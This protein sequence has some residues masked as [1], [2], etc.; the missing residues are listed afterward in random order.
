[1]LGF[2]RRT[3]RGTTKYKILALFPNTWE[4]GGKAAPP[5]KPQLRPPKRPLPLTAL[6]VAADTPD[7]I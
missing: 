6:G 3:Q 5:R 4:Y 7:G 2:E 1:M